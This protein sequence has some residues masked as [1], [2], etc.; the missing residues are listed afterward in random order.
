MTSPRSSLLVGLPEGRDVD[1]AHLEQR[2]HYLS[3]VPGSRVSHHLPERGR[4]DLP[5]HAEAI[6]EPAARTFFPAVRK[7]LPGVVELFLR[8]A[9][10]DERDPFGEREARAAI[11]RRE[12][13]PVE[14]EGRVQHAALRQRISVAAHDIHDLRFLMTET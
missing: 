2:L 9:G 10:R 3:R 6:L 14:L 12:L 4:N 1:L 8:V 13:P 7:P 11:H 5:R